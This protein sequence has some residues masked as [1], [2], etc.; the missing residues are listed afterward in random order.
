MASLFRRVNDI[1]N[2][3][4]NDLLDRIEDPE[5]MIKQLIREM[6][7]NIAQAKEGV[8]HAIASEKQLA[9]EIAD[10]RQQAST[11]LAKAETALAAGKEDLARAALA[12]KKEYE[13]IV[14]SLEPAWESARATSERLKT[15]L[16]Q[17]E[18]KLEEARHKRSSLLA[19]QRA[20]EARSH[21]HHTLDRFESGLEAQTR[22]TRMEEK[23]LEMEAR[24]EAQAELEDRSELEKQF[25]ELETDT[26]LE[27]ELEALR[28]KIGK[29]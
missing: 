9:R 5:R 19:R 27:A 23:V 1:I 2:S 29:P 28:A 26:E 10:H 7:A 22:F 3:N 11:W 15:Q 4:I 18:L 17:L 20:S 13:G 6:E 25:L 12:R 8:I 14:A 16:H 24:A 21:M